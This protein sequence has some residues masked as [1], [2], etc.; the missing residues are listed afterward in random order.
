M[1]KRTTFIGELM[2]F[3]KMFKPLIIGT[4]AVLVLSVTEKGQAED[5]DFYFM[6]GVKRYEAKDYSGCIFELNAAI[7]INSRDSIY[8]LYRGNCKSFDEDYYG[9]I[10][11]ITKS[12]DIGGQ[13]LPEAYGSRGIAKW[14]IGDQKGAC[15]DWR[16][17]Y[18]LGD[19]NIAKFI[20]NRCQIYKS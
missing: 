17:A 3:L 14:Q 10:S 5:A 9:A 18:S 12:I 4:G 8:Y 13:F 11:D 2:F 1:K 7:A 20:I 16:Q 15:S 6:R 19:D